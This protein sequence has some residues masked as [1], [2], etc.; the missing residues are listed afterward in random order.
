MVLGK[1]M[2]E[3]SLDSNFKGMEGILL[4]DLETGER[5]ELL[6]ADDKFNEI[7]SKLFHDRND[8]QKA[9]QK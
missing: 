5:V 1:K 9:A 4:M 6:L 7:W 8:E 3:V 2:L